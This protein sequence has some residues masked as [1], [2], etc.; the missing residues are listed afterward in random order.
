VTRRELEPGYPEPTTATEVEHLL[1]LVPEV[2]FMPELSACVPSSVAA[3]S[4]VI[5]ALCDEA[6]LA[7]IREALERLM[8]RA[9]VENR[10][11]LQFLA[12]TL[13]HFLTAERIAPSHHPLVVALFLRAE[14]A[15]GGLDDTP[16]AISRAMDRF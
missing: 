13:L 14:A 3:S 4:E 16:A 9:R 2:A 12:R 15:K 7:R 11:G 10:G 6:A 5:D 8:T 1:H